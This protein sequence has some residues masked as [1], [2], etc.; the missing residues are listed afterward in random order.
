M[1]GAVNCAE[2]G[3]KS[4]DIAWISVEVIL[5]CSVL[6]FANIYSR[7]YLQSTACEV[8]CIVQETSDQLALCKVRMLARQS[9]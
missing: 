3:E 8:Y 2:V 4:V 9:I 7:L 5:W 1:S 6:K